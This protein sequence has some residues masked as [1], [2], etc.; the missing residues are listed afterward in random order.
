[1]DDA[2]DVGTQPAE[3][4]V[5]EQI[6]RVN[7]PPMKICCNSFL[8]EHVLAHQFSNKEFS[9]LDLAVS[10]MMHRNKEKASSCA[11]VTRDGQ[12]CY[13]LRL[14]CVANISPNGF[15]TSWLLEDAI[16]DPLDPRSIDA[17]DFVVFKGMYIP[18]YP[19]ALSPGYPRVSNT[20]EKALQFCRDHPDMCTGVTSNPSTGEHCYSVRSSGTVVASAA[21]EMSWMHKEAVK[22]SVYLHSERQAAGNKNKKAR[23]DWIDKPM[24]E[25]VAPTGTFDNPQQ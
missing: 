10:A 17:P 13:T 1:M 9:T 24:F 2:A 8:S 6:P 19:M 21:G 11:R 20:L 4:I 12:G 15:D 23:C 18:C 5:I 7:S 14:G 25:S 16:K 22:R 3:V